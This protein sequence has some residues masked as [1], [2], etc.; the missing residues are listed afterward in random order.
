MDQLSA[1]H[2]VILDRYAYSGVAYSVLKGFNYDW[3]RSPDR[4]LPKPDCVVFLYAEAEALRKRSG[5]GAERYER[6]EIQ[7]EARRVFLEK[8][9]DPNWFVLDT[10]NLD[11]DAV[12]QRVN[13]MLD[14]R[15]GT[16]RPI[17]LDEPVGKLWD[18]MGQTSV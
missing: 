10:S 12:F 6:T 16:A 9:C 5:F 7:L 17:R 3:C 4:G 18:D 2:S 8:L 11:S 14:E 1:G 13:A 15:F